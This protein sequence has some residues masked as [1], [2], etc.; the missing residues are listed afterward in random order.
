MRDGLTRNATRDAVVT[1]L[2]VRNL[3]PR[4]NTSVTV[5]EES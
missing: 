5:E 2:L 1:G 4:I 3:L